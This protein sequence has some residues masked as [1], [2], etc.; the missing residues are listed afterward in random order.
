MLFRSAQRV[1]IVGAGATGESLVREMLKD[2]FSGFIPVGFV[3]DD[4]VKRGLEIHGVR[5][6]AKCGRIAEVTRD[7]A[8]ELVVLAV[9]AATGKEIRRLVDLCESVGVPVRTVPKLRDLMSGEARASELRSLSIDDLLGRD[10]VAL[11]W[12]SISAGVAG[13]TV[14]VTGGAG[15]IGSELC[16]QLVRLQP[17]RLIVADRSEFG[18]YEIEQDLAASVPQVDMRFYLRDV[19]DRVGLEQLVIKEKPELVFH[20][21]AYK[22][23]PMLEAQVREAVRNNVEGTRNMVE[24]AGIHGVATMVQIGRAHV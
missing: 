9:P 10:P 12:G 2:R 8:V 16:R 22:H 4:P 13:R 20:A 23:V 14:L 3:D 6:L 21:A 15:S 17:K 5:V 1:L 18:L 11:D 19:C 7:R 24:L